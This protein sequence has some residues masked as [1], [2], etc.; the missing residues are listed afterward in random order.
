MGGFA[1]FNLGMKH[2]DTFK[3]ILGLTA[4]LNLRWMNCRGRYSG[5]FDPNCWGWRE[6]IDRRWEV[7]GR[8]GAGTVKIRLKNLIE[9]LYDRS[10]DAIA[11]RATKTRSKCST[12]W[13]LLTASWICRGL[14]EER[15]LQHR[16]PGGKLPV[17]GQGARHLRCLQLRSQRPSQYPDRVRLLTTASTGLGR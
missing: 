7:I 13:G 15:R 3:I 2:R 17:R 4:T 8:F 16:R 9:P 11:Q 5:N 12:D 14:R 10:P 6:S 1:A